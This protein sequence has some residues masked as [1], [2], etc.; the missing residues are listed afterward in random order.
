MAGKRG[1]DW[2]DDARKLE[3]LNA[4]RIENPMKTPPNNV[5]SIDKDHAAR[6]R[7]EEGRFS[8][9]ETTTGG[10]DIKL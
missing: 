9:S 10:D 1:D 7:S 3:E 6:S 5:T 4:K 2:E 8:Q